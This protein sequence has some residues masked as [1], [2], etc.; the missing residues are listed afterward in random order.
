M[1]LHNFLLF[2]LR[3]HIKNSCFVFHQGLQTP[4]NNKSTR[5]AASCFHQFSRVWN[6]DETLALV[7]EILLSLSTSVHS[8]GSLNQWPS[9]LSVY[10]CEGPRKHEL[11][12]IALWSNASSMRWDISLKSLKKIVLS[13]LKIKLIWVKMK[14]FAARCRPVSSPSS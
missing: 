5:P 3:S 2:H 10:I 8:F 11:V 12:F 14:L 1:S 13:P 4:R 9:Y 6:P 7:F